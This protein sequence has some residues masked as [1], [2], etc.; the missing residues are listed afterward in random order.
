[1]MNLILIAPPAAGKGTQAKLIEKK[2]HIP[3]IS[4]GDILRNI[5]ANKGLYY[6]KIEKSLNNGKFV[7]NEI[8][9]NIVIDRLESNDCKYGY[10]L[11][12][13][14]RTLKQAELF[15]NYLEK[16]GYGNSI[17]ILIDLCKED[18]K[19]RVSNRICCT[20]C[21]RVYNLNFESLRPKVTGKCDDCGFK[22][23][24]RND[25]N[26]DTYETRYNKYV[27]DTEPVIN[28]YRQKGIL[29]V[30][31]GKKDKNLIFEDIKKII[32]NCF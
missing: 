16:K 22:L 4:T 8:V 15:D 17:T 20:N 32:D 27:E 6:E 26:F 5:V 18:A 10:I 29:H 13:F 12:G 23:I 25:D 31:D 14:P 24:K 21:G 19:L 28:Y 2:Y 1:M 7:D 11:D 3:H 9:F 30:V